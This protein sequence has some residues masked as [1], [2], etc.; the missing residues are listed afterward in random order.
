MTAAPAPSSKKRRVPV[1]QTDF[2]AIREDNFAYADKTK[3][4]PVLE[5]R[6]SP[7]QLIIRPRRFGKSVFLSMLK[8]YY[9][10]AQVDDFEKTFRDTYI[11]N[12]KTPE[13]GRYYVLHLDCSGVDNDNLPLRFAQR[14][15]SQLDQFLTH[16]DIPEKDD[17]IRSCA[18]SPAQLIDDFCHRFSTVLSKRVFLLVDEYDQFANAILSTNFQASPRDIADP[19]FLK[20]FYAVIQANASRIFRHIYITGVTPMSLGL[21]ASGFSIATNYSTNPDF[22]EAFGFTDDELRLLI[23]DTIDCAAFG[24]TNESIFLRMK[25]LY[26]GYRFTPNANRSVFHTSMCLEYLRFLREEKREPQGSELFDSSVAVDLSKIH[27][28]LSTGDPEFVRT[29]VSR[30][31]KGQVIPCQGL[32]KTLNLN[33]NKRFSN[34]DVLTALFSMGYLTFAP[35]GSQNL[36]CPNKTI[37]EQ[38]FGFYFKYLSDFGSVTFDPA[39]INAASVAMKDGDICPFMNYVAASLKTEVGLH[40]RLQLAE[41]PIQ[42]FMLGAARL[43]RGFRVTA[44]NEA[45]GIGYADL[46]FEPMAESGIR[47]S[48]LVELKYLPAGDA[49]EAA[50]ARKAEEARRQLQSYDA[51]PNLRRLPQLQKILVI[52]AGPEICCMEYVS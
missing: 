18:D 2:T 22:A 51:A 16:Y 42:F 52:F 23:Q 35:D 20:H 27:G 34:T 13:Q 8:A 5:N 40:G 29:V 43:L 12:H 7:Y 48:F 47:H 19:V 32:S 25:E 50:V 28:I 36:V 24:E 37:L 33:Q 17:F 26:N 46:L 38:F 14:I 44:E 31:L 45:F 3:L 15:K 41:A 1:G 11:F 21:M 9:D 39:M 30:A 49:S 6:D 4:I 10:I